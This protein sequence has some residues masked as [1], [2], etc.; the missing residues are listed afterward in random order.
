MSAIRGADLLLITSRREASPIVM[1]EAMTA[2]RPWISFDVGC[3]G[4]NCGSVI[5]DS[6]DDMVTVARDLLKNPTR[7]STLSDAGRARIAE[8]H[9]WDRIVDQYEA[10]YQETCHARG[11]CSVS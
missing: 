1:L 10:L 7:A 4:E 3:V 6:V 9:D 5:V 2:G 11:M 8:E